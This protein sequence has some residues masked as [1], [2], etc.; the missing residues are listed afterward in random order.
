LVGLLV[1]MRL[2]IIVDHRRTSIEELLD[3]VQRAQ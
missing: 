3:N 1:L 2:D